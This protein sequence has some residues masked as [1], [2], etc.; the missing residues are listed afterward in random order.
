MPRL[1]IGLG[2]V[3]KTPLHVTQP[4]PAYSSLYLSNFLS[5]HTLND[6]LFVKDSSDTVQARVVIFGMQIN[7]DVLYCGIANH[8]SP[9]YS[10]LYLSN[11]LSFHTLND[12]IFRQ[13]FL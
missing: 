1:G 10:S 5:F 3:T 6:E 2:G 7:N 12:E 8:P 13:R 4:S 9:S 11:F